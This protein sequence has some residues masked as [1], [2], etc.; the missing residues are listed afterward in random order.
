MFE[1]ANTRSIARS[2]KFICC[3]QLRPAPDKKASK[4]EQA[5]ERQSQISQIAEVTGILLL[6]AAVIAGAAYSS[7]QQV[8]A[9]SRT[10]TSDSQ[11]ST[12]QHTAVNLPEI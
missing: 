1:H 4:P 10:Q 3:F 2:D 6:L 11:V 8:T 12:V 7:K 5:H 9:A